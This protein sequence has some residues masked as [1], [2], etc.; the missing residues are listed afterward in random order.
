MP[1]LLDTKPADAAAVELRNRNC[2]EIGLVNNMPDAA[3]EA[4]ERQFVELIRAATGD[5]VVRLRLYALPD[6]PRGDRGRQETAA[7]YRDVAE[8]WDS[9]LDGLVVTGTEPRTA[10]LK[11]EPYW[12]PLAKLVIEDRRKVLPVSS[13]SRQSLWPNGGSRSAADRSSAR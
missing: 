12:P 8:L 7:R 3:L 11:E 6:V 9:R 2:I 1:L 4:T 5:S 13:R 10:D